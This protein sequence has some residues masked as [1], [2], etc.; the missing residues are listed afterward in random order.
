MD[1]QVNSSTVNADNPVSFSQQCQDLKLT[2]PMMM[3]MAKR[4]HLLSSNIMCRAKNTTQADK[5]IRVLAKDISLLGT[6]ISL[7]IDEARLKL[8]DLTVLLTKVETINATQQGQ[9]VTCLRQLDLV[10][11][12]I[13][14]TVK[15]GEYLAVYSSLE[16]I[17][18][19]AE[20]PY[21]DT[22]GPQ[23]KIVMTELKAYYQKQ[24]ALI[25]DMTERVQNKQCLA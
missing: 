20:Q 21:F 11:F 18:I 14:T 17:H 23:L 19:G 3:V 25:Q 12:P 15:K 7:S 4:L 8:Q 10:L 1:G 13:L 22:V 5:V 24:C 16:A 2:F 9:M 6:E